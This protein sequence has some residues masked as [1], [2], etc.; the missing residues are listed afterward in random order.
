MIRKLTS[1]PLIGFEMQAAAP[2]RIT[3][4]IEVCVAEVCVAEVC[5]AE[6]CAPEVLYNDVFFTA[7]F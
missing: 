3:R 5:V 1:K 7:I 4:I 6:A 2:K